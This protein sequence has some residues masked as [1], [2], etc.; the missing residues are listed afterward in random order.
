[1][2]AIPGAASNT[3]KEKAASA[4][5]RVREC[6]G[7]PLDRVGVERLDDARGFL[8]VLSCVA[9]DVRSV[10]AFAARKAR[11]SSRPSGDPIS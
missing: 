3:E 5:P 1:M 10:P 4:G 2:R 7:H 8:Q 6:A 11:V 9:H